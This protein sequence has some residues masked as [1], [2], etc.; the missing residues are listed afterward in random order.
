MKNTKY[1]TRL[2]HNDKFGSG[3]PNFESFDFSWYLEN[4]QGDLRQYTS[5]VNN[6]QFIFRENASI[7]H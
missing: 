5:Q 7:Y 6:I 2:P 4:E 1:I 3:G